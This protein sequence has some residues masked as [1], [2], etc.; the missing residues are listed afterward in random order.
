M[1]TG[2]EFVEHSGNPQVQ[3]HGENFV[4]KTLLV[5]L[6]HHH[7][8]NIKGRVLAAGDHEGKWKRTIITFFGGVRN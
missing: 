7:R 1:K 8:K 5:F 2:G 4:G 6:Q 3:P